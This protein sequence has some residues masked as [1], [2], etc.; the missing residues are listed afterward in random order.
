M[1]NL[2]L[3]TSLPP[4]W[5]T[6]LEKIANAKEE[7]HTTFAS[8]FKEW[9]TRKIARYHRINEVLSEYEAKLIVKQTKVKRIV[10]KTQEFRTL[11]LIRFS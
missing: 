9:E 8:S 3:T 10:F 6:N 2:Y 11:F 5:W 7:Y 4:T 1:A